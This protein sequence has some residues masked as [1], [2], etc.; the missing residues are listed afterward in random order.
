[1]SNDKK[2][3]FSNV[4]SGV[5]SSAPPA[6]PKA[7]FSNVVSGVESTAPV[8]EPEPERVTHTVAKGETLSAIAKQH[9]GKASLWPRIYAANR[10]LLNDPDR[11]KPGQVLTIPAPDREA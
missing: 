2:A 10:D 6:P 8:I 9:Y 11:I 1:M 3:D 5:T 4:Q 7:D